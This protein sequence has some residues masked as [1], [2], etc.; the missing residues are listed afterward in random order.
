[1]KFLYTLLFSFLLIPFLTA[2]LTTTF[3]SFNGNQ[4]FL[5]FGVANEVIGQED[6]I[7]DL[8]GTGNPTGTLADLETFF[9]VGGVNIPSGEITF[10]FFD[11]S[12][13]FANSFTVALPQAGDINWTITIGGGFLI[14]TEGIVQAFIDPASGVQGRWFLV[15]EVLT[16]GAIGSSPDNPFNLGPTPD[17]NP[18][19]FT[20]RL[21]ITGDPI[22]EDDCPVTRREDG[23]ILN[24][25]EID[26][27][28]YTAQDSILS[29]GTVPSPNVVTFEA[30]EIIIL[31]EGFEALNGST[32]TAR[33]QACVPSFT[34]GQGEAIVTAE[35]GEA[36]T[37]TPFVTGVEGRSNAVAI[38]DK[39]SIYPNP[40][41]EQTMVEVQLATQSDLQVELY[42]LSGSKVSTITAQRDVMAGTHQFTV[43]ADQLEG[44]MYLLMIR[45]DDGIQTRK[46]SLVK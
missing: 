24:N 1:M 38:E 4:G 7:M 18:A 33:I 12:G 26:S 43:D 17:G 29:I 15:D 35:A 10:S 40:F 9:F 20:M 13:A 42:D 21:D 46:L 28:T 5:G 14:P 44:G 31:E 41:S 19:V 2:Q 36:V 22:S 32:F 39:V 30:G 25:D 8:S 27:D 6:Y 37:A 3:D 45:T 34:G 11:N 16:T 23:D